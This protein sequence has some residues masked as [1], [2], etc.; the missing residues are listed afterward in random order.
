MTKKSHTFYV[1]QFLLTLR[2]LREKK[3]PEPFVSVTSYFISILDKIKTIKWLSVCKNFCFFV[4]NKKSS[5]YPAL[6]YI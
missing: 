5:L 1:G 2:F 4:N 3:G 6:S